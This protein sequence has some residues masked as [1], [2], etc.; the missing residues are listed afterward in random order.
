MNS[1]EELVLHVIKIVKDNPAIGLIDKLTLWL[2]GYNTA[3]KEIDSP[4]EGSMLSQRANSWTQITTL[5]DA[6]DSEWHNAEG[7]TGIE[8][9]LNHLRS[10]VRKTKAYDA[11]PEDKK[12]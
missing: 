5:L 7:D 3:I 2:D 11:L 8:R 4:T 12:Q 6:I 1:P 10:L 9:M